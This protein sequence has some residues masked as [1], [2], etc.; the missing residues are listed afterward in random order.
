MSRHWKSA[1]WVAAIA[2]LGWRA[3]ACG[4]DSGGGPAP[5]FTV[6]V[7]T[8]AA[9]TLGTQVLVHVH[10]T[11]I[12]DSGTVALTVTGAD[13]TWTVTPPVGPVTL[14][15]NGQ[16]TAN[17]TIAIPTNGGPAPT[18]RAISIGATIGSHQHGAATAITV[19]NE[20]VIPIVRGSA[21]HWPYPNRDSL[22]V[23][24]GTVVTFRN[25][26][27]LSHIIHSNGGVGI[28]HQSIGVGTIPGGTY[29]Q[30]AAGPSGSTLITCHSHPADT[31]RIVVP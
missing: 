20:F 4:S 15:L 10:L 5:D 12:G 17:V 9:T 2:V 8:P 18:G 11:S 14:S 25:D 26:D 31:L 22:F 21:A 27:T 3:S 16:T 23:N 30:T 28:A 7:D 6:V 19:A 24:A 13:T 1:A 29:S